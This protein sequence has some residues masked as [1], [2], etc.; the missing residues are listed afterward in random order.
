MDALDAAKLGL[1]TV[2]HFYGHFE[3]LLKDY[4][5]QPWPA[6][7]VNDNEQM[8][9]GQVARLW[10]K[11]HPPGSPEWK[12]YLEE[13]L[14]LGTTF[15]PTMTAY[16]AGRDLMRMRNADWH[17][18]YSLPS[19]MDFYSPSRANHGAYWYYWTLED[20]IAWRNFYQVW[21][22]LLNDYKKMGGRVTVSADAAYI[23]NTYGFGNI[24]EMEL[25]Q[26]AGFH[27]LE[28]IQAATYNA[29]KTLAESWGKPMDRGHVRAGML[30]DLLIVDQNPL[31]N[32]KVLYGTGALRLNDDTGNRSGSAASGTR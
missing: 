27:P 4:V 22:R 16:A 3:A 14:E 11:I 24:H 19:L 21:F 25:L 2:T 15:D 28:V 32:L 7:Q 5:V 30:A 23:Y 10:D 26:E 29:A 31:K 1:R 18:R 17:S 9:F 8:R 20:E 6:D 12:A 13:H